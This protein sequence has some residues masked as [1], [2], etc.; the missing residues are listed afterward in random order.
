MLSLL[1]DKKIT[2]EA[3]EKLGDEHA[4]I[5][6]ELLELEDFDEKN[7]KACCPY[8]GEDTPSFIYDKKTKRFHCFGCNV[9]VD[10]IDVLMEKGKTF[11][12]AT[13]FLFDKAGMKYSFGEQ[14]VK[15]KRNYKYPHEEPLN[16]RINVLNYLEKR[17][18][19]KRVV[20]YLDIREDARGNIVFNFC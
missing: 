9:T 15:T 14:D 7:L 20:D 12:D 16:E 13:K 4:F 11:L 2:E 8:H 6:A 19:S 18:I 5:M 1:I 10:I 17:G 3:K